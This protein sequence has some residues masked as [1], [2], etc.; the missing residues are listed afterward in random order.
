LAQ[1]ILAQASCQS[2]FIKVPTLKYGAVR[3]RPRG[4]ALEVIAVLIVLA[5]L[6][7]VMPHT[8]SL[9]G[10]V[11]HIDRAIRLGFAR[12]CSVY[13]PSIQVPRPFLGDAKRFVAAKQTH[14]IRASQADHS[15]KHS[16]HTASR[17]ARQAGYIDDQES[18]RDDRINKD[19]NRARHVVSQAQLQWA[20]QT[21]CSLPPRGDC[22]PSPAG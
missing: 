6:V 21:Q 12:S 15:D 3:R 17:A 10:K 19:A 1:A 22:A 8:R 2:S 9:A 18:K 20:T 4:D 13:N 11:K 5:S 16:L 14:A 7:I